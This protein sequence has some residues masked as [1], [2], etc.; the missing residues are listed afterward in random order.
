MNNKEE[1][2]VGNIIIYVNTIYNFIEIRYVIDHSFSTHSCKLITLAR[3][4]IVND[5]SIN[6]SSFGYV[7][8]IKAK[9]I[10]NIKNNQYEFAST[11]NIIRTLI[12]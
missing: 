6:R 11:L 4:S 5:I 10:L 8:I 9:D 3:H 2:L 7:R 12:I 1:T